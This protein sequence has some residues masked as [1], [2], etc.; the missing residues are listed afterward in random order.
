[1]SS[2]RV[3]DPIRP[4]FIG[5]HS[6]LV[7]LPPSVRPQLPLLNPTSCRFPEIVQPP[8][9]SHNPVSIV[10]APQLLPFASLVLPRS[11]RLSSLDGWTSVKNVVSSRLTLNVVKLYERSAR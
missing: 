4:F 6:S 2:L 9:T 1:M 5:H 10:P 8:L 3:Q 7:S 11:I